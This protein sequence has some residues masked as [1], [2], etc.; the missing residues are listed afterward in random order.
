MGDVQ[1]WSGGWPP[2]QSAQ[3]P[4]YGPPAV[5]AFG[6]PAPYASP[7]AAMRAAHTD[8]ERT[9]DVL[10]AAFAEGRLSAQEYGER[11]EAASSAQTY[12]QL[13]QLVADLPAGPGLA[14]PMAPVPAAFLPPPPPPVFRPAPN[15]GAAVAAM[16][17]GL[18]CVP[19]MGLTGLP[20]VLAG[21][22]ARGQI[23]RTKE[24]GDGMALT[25]LVLGYLSL[26]GWVLF[27]L[28]AVLAVGSHNG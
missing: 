21:H 11:F 27:I 4:A 16:V 7:Q 10:K 25:G 6:V 8:R 26:A 18:L 2:R 19:T 15:N 17:L 9:V 23:N 12:G 28:A 24:A 5:A 3:P 13:A 22:A 14:P 1:S 20:A